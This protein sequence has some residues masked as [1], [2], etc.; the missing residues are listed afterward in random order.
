MGSSSM[1]VAATSNGLS[2]EERWNDIVQFTKEYLQYLST[3][4]GV[5]LTAETRLQVAQMARNALDCP[6]CT[7]LPKDTCLRK[8]ADIYKTIDSLEMHSA[9]SDPKECTLLHLVHSIVNHQGR[10]TDSWHQMTLQKLDECG[11]VDE[12]VASKGS[13]IRTYYLYSLV[14]EI[15]I[16]TT[17][18]HSLNTVFLVM[19]EEMP[20]TPQ[21]SPDANPPTYFDWSVAIKKG[22][23]TSTKGCWAPYLTTSQVNP[24]SPPIKSLDADIRKTL[25]M[26]AMSNKGPFT[27]IH[28]SPVDV[29]WLLI[30]KS[31]LYMDSKDMVA[32]FRPL[33]PETRCAQSFSRRDVEL[34]AGAVAEAYDCAF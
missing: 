15:T 29:Y 1:S 26:E 33:S 7:A 21:L 13:T 16:V 28:W 12:K 30:M 27:A 18:M 9:S 2:A 4:G 5:V 17:I 24:K 32:M 8:G 20:N 19:N 31:V 25:L 11:F 22:K 3:I 14:S 34:I 6:G 23:S 10:L